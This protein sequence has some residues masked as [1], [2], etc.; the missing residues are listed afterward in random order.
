MHIETHSKQAAIRS[1]RLAATRGD[2]LSAES[3]CEFQFLS[4]TFEHI[5]DTEFCLNLSQ[6]SR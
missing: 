1:A 3:P 5:I 4:A 2:Q 6:L